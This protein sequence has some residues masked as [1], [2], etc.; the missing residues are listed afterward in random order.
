MWLSTYRNVTSGNNSPIIL[1]GCNYSGKP[2]HSYLALLSFD[3]YPASQLNSQSVI[4]QGL[5]VDLGVQCSPSMQCDSHYSP[6]SRFFSSIVWSC[7]CWF[8]YGSLLKLFGFGRVAQCS[9]KGDSISTFFLTCTEVLHTTEVF[10]FIW[11]LVV[12][13]VTLKNKTKYKCLSRGDL[14][15]N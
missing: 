10:Y 12:L 2:N 4:T 9:R 13:F 6:R 15:L 7:L 3:S 14:E 8:F 1:S 5:Q 11:V